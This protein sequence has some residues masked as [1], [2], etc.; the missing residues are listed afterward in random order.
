VTVCHAAASDREGSVRLALHGASELNEVM[1]ADSEADRHS[2][3]SETV[4]CLTLDGLIAQ[5]QLTRV[6]LLKIDAE[7]H[8]IQVL[9]GSDRLLREFAPIILYENIAKGQQDNFPA[10]EFLQ[11]Y[12]YQLFRYQPYV[13]ELL[14]VSSVNDLQGSLNIIAIVTHE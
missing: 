4:P 7:G 13:K 1:T 10:A 11:Q 9:K 3:Q 5:N 14:P 12:G 6:D 2:N 8:E